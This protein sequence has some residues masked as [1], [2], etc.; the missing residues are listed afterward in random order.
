MG[1]DLYAAHA[2]VREIF[3]QAS[4]I[5][6]VDLAKLCFEGPLTELTMTVNLQPA[7]TAV[8]LAC[9]AAVVRAGWQPDVSAGHSLGEF[10]ALVAAGV[11]DPVDALRLVFR[12]GEL[13]HREACAHEGAMH[14]LI[15][16]DI[17]S[18][19]ALVDAFRGEGTVSVA[20]HNTEQQIVITGSPAAVAQVASKAVARGARAVPLKVSGAWHSDLIQGAESEL[21][22]FMDTL[23][24][25]A[26]RLP[27]VHN[28]TADVA[29][30]AA[31]IKA[32][33][34]RQLCSPVRWYDS[35]RRLVQDGVDIFVEVG[36][37]KVLTGLVRKIVPK[38][39][40]CRLFQV[41]DIASL[42]RLLQTAR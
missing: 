23:D 30:E 20:N 12:R 34:G 11:L 33:M 36:P 15:G 21:V 5:A 25:H 26:P 2:F 41:G 28:L 16:L 32:V 3:E 18:V 24:F 1:A 19:Q 39:C 27:V 10:S 31:T 22:A 14:A 4:D 29:P 7:V 13:M 38:D 6:R 8:N 40:E 9:H 17:D 37:G 35:I 42:E